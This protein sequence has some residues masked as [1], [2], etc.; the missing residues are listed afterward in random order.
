MS[1][2]Q[3]P[4]TGVS[5]HYPAG[6]LGQARL[7]FS[8]HDLQEFIEALRC[9][10]QELEVARQQFENVNDPLLIDH[11]VFRL[12]AAERHFNYLFQLARK[13]GLDAGGVR[14]DWRDDA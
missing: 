1:S 5:T 3:E 7:S 8:E 9:S 6:D 12:G 14:W 11:V 10:K 13:L 2:S 4:V